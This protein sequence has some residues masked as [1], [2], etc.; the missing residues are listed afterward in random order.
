MVDAWRNLARDS[1]SLYVRVMSVAVGSAM[2]VFGWDLLFNPNS[3]AMHQP[4]FETVKVIAPLMTWGMGA[5]GTAFLFFVA[6]VSGR[7]AVYALAIVSGILVQSAWFA[8]IM[9]AKFFLGAPM[10]SATTGIWLLAISLTVGTAF[11]PTPLHHG[12]ST[13]R[14]VN[15]SDDTVVELR[16][17]G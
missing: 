3:V 8:S 1:I 15:D 12:S 2:I 13:I 5:W 11:I 9:Y 4:I 17:A 6:A 10:S 7:F 16:R 14:V